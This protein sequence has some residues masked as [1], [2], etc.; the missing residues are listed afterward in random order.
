MMKIH[1]ATCLQIV[2]FACSVDVQNFFL[3][4]QSFGQ[5]EVL[6]IESK[7][8]LQFLSKISQE[9]ALKSV[10]KKDGVKDASGRGTP[11]FSV[12]QIKKSIAFKV[13]K[14]SLERVLHM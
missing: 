3:R 6:W 8:V 4:K 5:Q 9:L 12:H 11:S 14:L 1:N 10:G 2:N 7:I 13:L